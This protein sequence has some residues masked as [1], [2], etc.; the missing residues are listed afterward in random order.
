LFGNNQ[1]EIHQCDDDEAVMADILD[2]GDAV[3]VFVSIKS[4]KFILEKSIANSLFKNSSSRVSV[5]KPIQRSK[6]RR[7]F[8]PSE[9]LLKMP[10]RRRYWQ[11]W[12]AHIIL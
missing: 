12:Y 8:W 6:R 11:I 4:K 2:S 7:N 9:K 3:S 10:G 5:N 1:G